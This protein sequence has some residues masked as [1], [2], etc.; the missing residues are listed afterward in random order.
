MLEGVALAYAASQQALS[1][2]MGLI[3][4]SAGLAALHGATLHAAA[5]GQGAF[6]AVAA[7]GVGMLPTQLQA[8]GAES[9]LL[10]PDSAPQTLLRRMAERGETLATA[11]A[12]LQRR[13]ADMGDMAGKATHTRAHALFG[14]WQG[15]WLNISHTQRSG[16]DAL[17]P[18]HLKLIQTMGFQVVYGA[19]LRANGITT[20][21]M[22]LPP[23]A[24]SPQSGIETLIATSATG[25]HAFG[26]PSA[27]GLP[28]ALLGAVQ[29]ALSG[30]LRHQLN[31]PL[32]AVARPAHATHTLLIAPLA[33]QRALN[34]ALPSLGQAVAEEANAQGR[35]TV[36]HSPNTSLSSATIPSGVLTIPLPF[37]PTHLSTAP[38]RH[39][40]LVG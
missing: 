33:Q 34:A 15:Q 9:V 31:T 39:L 4:G 18:W 10:L 2:G 14:A 12:E 7:H 32:Q 23:E 29:R 37:A 22:A 5:R 20:G 28:S 11:T 13:G 35:A 40:R 36:V 25:T 27:S 30:T 3:V 17:E 24:P 21:L 16:L 6:F 8:I 38:A 1:Q 19:E 26:L